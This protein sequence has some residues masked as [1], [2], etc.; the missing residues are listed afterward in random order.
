[1]GSLLRAKCNHCDFDISGIFYGTGMKNEPAQIPAIEKATG[2]FVLAE[3]GSEN[4]FRYYH[5][6]DMYQGNVHDYLDSIQDGDIVL[7]QNHNLCPLC[8]HFTMDFVPI[9]D[10]D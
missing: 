10:W 8:G 9:G 7:S 2:A 4:E 1:M 3:P 6:P 5:Q